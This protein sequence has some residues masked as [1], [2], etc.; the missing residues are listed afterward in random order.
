M[1]Y[2]LHNN[3]IHIDAQNYNTS[4]KLH[5]NPQDSNTNKPTYFH[6]PKLTNTGYRSFQEQ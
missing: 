1:F 2:K 5:T 4:P 3:H 6:I